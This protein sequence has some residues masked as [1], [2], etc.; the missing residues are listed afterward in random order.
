MSCLRQTLSGI[1]IYVTFYV[2]FTLIIFDY[3]PSKQCDLSVQIVHDKF[4]YILIVTITCILLGFS[5][6][7]HVK[8][9]IRLIIHMPIG[10]RVEY[11][12]DTCILF[13]I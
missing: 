1:T 5:K 13:Y 4:A 10:I 11:S 7:Q 12:I 6:K 9:E 2:Y 3:V 8:F